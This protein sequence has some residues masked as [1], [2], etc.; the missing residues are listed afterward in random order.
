MCIV[1]N[2]RSERADEGGNNVSRAADVTALEHCK[3]WYKLIFSAGKMSWSL[4]FYKKKF[5]TFIG[6]SGREL[7]GGSYLASPSAIFLY[8]EGTDK[9]DLFGLGREFGF[10]LSLKVQ[11]WSIFA[12]NNVRDSLQILTCFFVM[13]SQEFVV[14]YYFAENKW[15]ILHL[16]FLFCLIA[17]SL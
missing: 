9:W 8:Q 12:G 16:W 14:F 10:V 7:F 15:K 6:M 11:I 1:V 4:D 5:V 13:F 2:F 17:T 3:M